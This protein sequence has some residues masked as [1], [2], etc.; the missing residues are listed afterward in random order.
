M[1]PA[2]RHCLAETFATLS[3]FYKVPNG[4]AAELTWSLCEVLT[5][6][7]FTLRDYQTA[8]AEAPKRGVMGGGIYDSLHATSARR[9]GAKRIATRNPGHF[10]HVAPEM[11]ILTPG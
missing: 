8:I 4:Q 2:R 9:F 7:C 5:V 6:E 11:E 10:A 3:G 1:K